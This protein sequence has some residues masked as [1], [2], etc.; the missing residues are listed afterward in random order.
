MRLGIASGIGS[1]MMD[2][3]AKDKGA[4]IQAVKEKRSKP[5]S[6]HCAAFTEAR[7]WQL[8]MLDI[9]MGTCMDAIW[10]L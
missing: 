5:C 4:R 8:D 9:V 1:G 6:L 10:P 2:C 3:L 7:L